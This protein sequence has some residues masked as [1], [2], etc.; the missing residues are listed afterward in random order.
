[1]D[2]I[3]YAAFRCDTVEEENGLKRNPYWE[4]NPVQP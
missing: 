4:S 2:T 3:E 1:M